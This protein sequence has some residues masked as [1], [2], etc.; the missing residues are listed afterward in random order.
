MPSADEG[1]ARAVQTLLET[2]ALQV[3]DPEFDAWCDKTI[4]RY[5]SV[6]RG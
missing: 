1:I 4:A 3:P 2:P 6:L 5:F